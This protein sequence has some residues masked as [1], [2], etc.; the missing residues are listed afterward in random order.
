M[1]G[2]GILSLTLGRNRASVGYCLFRGF[3]EKDRDKPLPLSLRTNPNGSV[4]HLDKRTCPRKWSLPETLSRIWPMQAYRSV[5]GSLLTNV[6]SHCENIFLNNGVFR[7]FPLSLEN[8][9]CDPT[10]ISASL[11]I[12]PKRENRERE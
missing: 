10:I 1:N 7:P 8:I 9:S 4:N 12:S 5:Q 6:H 2:I 3:L 11:C